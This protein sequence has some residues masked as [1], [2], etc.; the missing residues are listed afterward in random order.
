VYYR[1]KGYKESEIDSFVVEVFKAHNGNYGCPRI[2]AEAN[3]R[4]IIVSKRRIGKILKRNGL[5]SKH[6]RRKMAKNIY[7][8]Q[9]ER[10]IAENLIK[11]IIPKE[12]NEIWQ[13]DYT[14]FRC[15]DGKLYTD[16]IIDVYDKTVTLNSSAR[17]DAKMSEGT[18]RKAVER[19]GLPKTLHTDRGSIYVSRHMREL[20]EAFNIR[21]SMSA[22]HSPNENQYIETFWKTLKTE[23]GSAKHFTRDE[24][25]KVLDYYV[26][27]YNNE[28]IHSSIDYLTPSERRSKFELAQ[29]LNETSSHNFANA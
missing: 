12:S 19:R 9:E 10:Y 27:Y 4:G 3:K 7:T 29:T 16:G 14:E 25:R 11:G 22:P 2:K 6:G 21:R 23:I 24:L 17:A 8:A 20:T 28:R 1:K 26:D 15:K 18:V 5:E 13:M